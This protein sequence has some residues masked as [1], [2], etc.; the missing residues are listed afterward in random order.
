MNRIAKFEAS[1]GQRTGYFYL[2][3]S[4]VAFSIASI[5]IQKVQRLPLYQ[6]VYFRGVVQ[7]I[8]SWW[9]CTT[10]NIEFYPSSP[11]TI[12]KLFLRGTSSF[13]GFT[14]WVYGVQNLTLSEATTLFQCG[15]VFTGLFAIY[16]LK[17]RIDIIQGI[18]LVL[19]LF[20]SVLV[21][22]PPF[23]FQ[24]DQNEDLSGKN[25]LVGG[26]CCLCT[27]VAYGT[28]YNI[29]R[30]LRN[31]CHT[32]TTVHYIAIVI[33]ISTPILILTQGAETPTSTEI[34]HCVLMSAFT[35]LNQFLVARGLKF[36]TAGKTSIMGYSSILF[37]LAMDLMLHNPID[38]L[39][40][41]GAA[42]ISSCVI[43][44]FFEKKRT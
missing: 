11:S 31:S 33:S 7:F 32:Q 19:S 8:I 18:C 30:E 37:T 6:V 16:Y 5:F 26:I 42:C 36:G 40:L 20:G 39:S 25:R 17:E 41:A 43:G 35:M 15:P 34:I 28:S 13:I 27:A 21:L 2:L 1:G 3:L 4:N 9:V 29:V 14:F 12:K 23:L 22:K 44:L 38:A 24:S 10:N